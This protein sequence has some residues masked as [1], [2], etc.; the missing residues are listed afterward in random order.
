LFQL[1]PLE[2]DHGQPLVRNDFSGDGCWRLFGGA[3]ADAAHLDLRLFILNNGMY[4]IVEYG[5]E[6]IL[7][8]V[9]PSHYHCQLPLI[10][11]VAAAKAH[12]WEGFK[13]K[14]DL[15][16]LKEII[17]ICYIRTNQ[18][19]LIEVPVDANQMIG[20]TPRYE[21]LKIDTYL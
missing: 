6:V 4:A 17:E 11:F 18:S 8:E 9:E 16:N 21:H 15:S 12:G 10:D 5:L 19:I 3:L 2:V 7:P 20:L 1:K 13:L 14:P